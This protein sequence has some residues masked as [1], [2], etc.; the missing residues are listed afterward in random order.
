MSYGVKIYQSPG[1]YSKTIL[2]SSLKN[3]FL[4]MFTKLYKLKYTFIRESE[5]FH[6]N[7]KN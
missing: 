1:F 3:L 4:A 2:L 6:S 5:M 7:V